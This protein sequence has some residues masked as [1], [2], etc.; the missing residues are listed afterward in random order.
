MTA[1]PWLMR[2]AD[3]AALSDLRAAA[4]ACMAEVCSC[5]PS[6]CEHAEN[7]MTPAELVDW[8][9]REVHRSGQTAHTSEMGR[10]LASDSARRRSEARRL[11]SVTA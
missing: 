10:A 3:P 1:R 4:T 2:F 6:D 8:I 9:E 5:T 11:E 7:R